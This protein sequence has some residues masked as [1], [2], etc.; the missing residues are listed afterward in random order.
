M[1]II[2]KNK[3]K[4]F[5]ENE[6]NG[7]YYL[8]YPLFEETKMVKHG[9]STRLGG[10]SK[11]VCSTMNFSFS[12][13]DREEDVRENFRRMSAALEV[14]EENIVFQIRRTRQMSVL[15]QKRTEERDL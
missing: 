4:I 15:S 11:G 2:Y 7:V 8:T 5:Q 13:G 9:F 6:K 12:R 3:E 10:V 1:N 14:Q